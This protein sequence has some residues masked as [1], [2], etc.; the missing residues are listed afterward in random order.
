MPR[1]PLLI[2]LLVLPPAASIAGARL[3]ERL[4]YPRRFAE[5][6]P[7]AIYRAG[8]P[9]A[10]HL[11]RL[12]ADKAIRT[13]V[14]L[15]QP[16]DT[17][18]ETLIRTTLQRLG[19][20]HIRIPMPGDGRG[21][22][23]DLDIAADALADTAAWPLLFHCAAGKQRSNATLAAYRLR[24]CGWT[25]DQALAELESRHDLDRVAEADLCDHLRRYA[26]RVVSG[27]SNRP[28]PPGGLPGT[29]PV[30]P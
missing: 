27:G 7:G 6:L 29:M 8:Q 11:D 18:E 22:F 20:R 1:A 30:R 28:S 26:L 14:N 3:H 10:A 12:V 2:A 17:P 9:N 13:V 25:I 21:R 23:E 4:T 5:V 15:T 16:R 24:R 19:V